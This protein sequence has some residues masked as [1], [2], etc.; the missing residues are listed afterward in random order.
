MFHVC[1]CVSA[2]FWL[3]LVNSVCHGSRWVGVWWRIVRAGGVTKAKTGPNKEAGGFSHGRRRW[4]RGV[5]SRRGLSEAERRATPTQ[6]FLFQHPSAHFYPSPSF[7]LALSVP[8]PPLFFSFFW[9]ALLTKRF[10]NPGWYIIHDRL[11]R[12]RFRQMDSEKEG[13]MGPVWK[14]W[15]RRKWKGECSFMRQL[16]KNHHMGHAEYSL[17]FCILRSHTLNAHYTAFMWEKTLWGQSGWGRT[18]IFLH[19]HVWNIFKRCSHMSNII[20]STTFDF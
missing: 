5:T 10:T 19:M 14:G 9:N 1:L 13:G 2:V 8:S 12:D 18:V 4:D 11:L 15:R 7:Y 16:Y 6:L 20:M 3:S 17:F